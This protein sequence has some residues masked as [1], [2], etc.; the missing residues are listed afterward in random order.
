MPAAVVAVVAAAA[1]WIYAGRTDRCTPA[2]ALVDF[3]RE[4]TELLESKE[5]FPAEGSMEEPR[6]AADAEYRQW[7]DGVRERARAVT[8]PQLAPHAQRISDA[9]ARYLPLREQFGAE[10]DARSPLDTS[11]A[12]TPSMVEMGRLTNE[13]ATNIDAIETICS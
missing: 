7:V 5:H 8:D 12:P 11:S 3:H 1:V 9:V 6:Q 10:M 4:Q 13:L 2:T